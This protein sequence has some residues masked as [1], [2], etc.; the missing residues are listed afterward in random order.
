MWRGA[1][2]VYVVEL[3]KTPIAL[4]TTMG[5]IQIQ[6]Y[7]TKSPR[8]SQ[9]IL[10]YAKSGF[11]N[12][13]LFHR[14]VGGFVVQGL[15]ARYPNT[16]SSQTVYFGARGSQDFLGYGLVDTSINYD[17]PVFRTLKPW[18]KF[19][20]YNLFNNEKLIGWST[21]VSPNKATSADSLGLP[22]GYTPS[23]RSERPQATP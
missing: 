14:V 6:L 8:S 9:N 7:G 13:T 16:P 1:D 3:Y 15:L 11:Y 21:T 22:T 5:T 20:V 17:V 10:N 12:G 4:E 19:D 23:S 18:V 2:I